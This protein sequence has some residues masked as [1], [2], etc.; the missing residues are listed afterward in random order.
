MLLNVC[1]AYAGMSGNVKAVSA[2]VVCEGHAGISGMRGPCGVLVACAGHTGR[3]VG[4]RGLCRYW[5]HAQTSA[6]NPDIIIKRYVILTWE[7]L[8]HIYKAAYIMHIKDK[9]ALF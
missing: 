1:K 3:L 6:R 7:L 8:P 9:Y 4:M 2:L 5:W